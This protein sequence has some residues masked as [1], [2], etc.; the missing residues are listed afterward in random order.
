MGVWWLFR[1]VAGAKKDAKWSRQRWRQLVYSS[2]K[3]IPFPLQLPLQSRIKHKIC[4]QHKSGPKWG[5]CK[6]VIA[7]PYQY[8]TQER[9]VSTII[10]EGREVQ[11]TTDEVDAMSAKTYG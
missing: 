3:T 9:L 11:Y 6:D 1:E 4:C 10:K 5:T 7:P 2:E 8:K